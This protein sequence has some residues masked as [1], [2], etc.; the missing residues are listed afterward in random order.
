MTLYELKVYDDGECAVRKVI[1]RNAYQT[2]MLFD[3]QVEL[4][5]YLTSFLFIRWPVTE[6]LEAIESTDNYEWTEFK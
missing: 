3:S 1:R 2:N 4:K 6:V 5:D